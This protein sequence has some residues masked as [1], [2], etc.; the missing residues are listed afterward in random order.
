MEQRYNR[1][2]FLGEA[3][4]R[5]FATA[6]VGILGLGGGG[7]HVVQQLAHLGIKNFVVCDPDKVED[8]NL[9]RLVGA[10]RQ[11][12]ENSTLKVEIAQRIVEGLHADA[13]IVLLPERW[14]ENAECL[15]T[16]DILV[17]C[18]DS[19]LGRY[20]IEVFSRR[21]LIPYIDIGMDVFQMGNEPPRMVGQVILS[22]PG[23]HCL[24]C[25]GLITDKNL[26]EEGTR[27]GDAGGRP[28]VVWANGVLASAAV[29]TVVDL[30]TDWTGSIRRVVYLSYDGNCNLL[31]PDVR[32][33]YLVDSKCT[34]YD[35]QV[36]GDPVFRKV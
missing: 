9:N 29:G 6:K 15:K 7:S 36:V 13:H 17:G 21:Y 30:L 25:L 3:S 28:Q 18:V 33:K 32:L 24:W 16:C 23:D 19:Y 27:Y 12:V 34:H 5:I 20:E 10:T 11:D 2:S 8:T 26:A 14:Q 1:Q 22:I 31:R 35:S 4:E